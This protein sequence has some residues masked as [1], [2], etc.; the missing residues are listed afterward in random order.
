MRCV[1]RGDKCSLI[2]SSIAEASSTPIPIPFS[3]TESSS[4][5]P[6]IPESIP[7]LSATREDEAFTL[8]NIELFHRF[9]SVTCHHLVNPNRS[10]PWLDEIPAMSTKHPFLLHEIMALAAIDLSR[11]TAQSHSAS[12]SR[13]STTR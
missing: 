5:P 8:T 11:D 13:D 10:S 4:N 7:V 6:S 3:T 2:T 12:S 1:K 9:T